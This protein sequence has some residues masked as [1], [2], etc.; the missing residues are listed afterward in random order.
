MLER[1]TDLMVD[2]VTSVMVAFSFAG[3]RQGPPTSI[4]VSPSVQSCLLLWLSN[5]YIRY[6]RASA[7]A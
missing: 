3:K 2:G 7:H 4:P 1:A 6:V 5:A